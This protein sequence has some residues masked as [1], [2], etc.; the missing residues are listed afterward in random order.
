MVVEGFRGEGVPW[1]LDSVL[2]MVRVGDKTKQQAVYEKV[3]PDR[4]RK[5]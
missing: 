1:K 4:K 3:H 2:G 5:M